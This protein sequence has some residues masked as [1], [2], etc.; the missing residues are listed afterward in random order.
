MAELKESDCRVS[1]FII[2]VMEGG[3]G[4]TAPARRAACLRKSCRIIICRSYGA[5]ML[6]ARPGPGRQ[7]A[8]ARGTTLLLSRRFWISCSDG[9][10]SLVRAASHRHPVHPC[11]R[12]AT[13]SAPS[14]CPSCLAHPQRSAAGAVGHS[15][16][17]ELGLP[18]VT[19]PENPSE[20]SVANLARLL[21]CSTQGPPAFARQYGAA[22]PRSKQ[23]PSLR[24]GGPCLCNG[25]RPRT[26]W[27]AAP[28]RAS[29]A[30]I[31]LRSSNRRRESPA[32]HSFPGH[33]RSDPLPA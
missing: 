2:V 1:G 31:V 11:D 19:S 24:R 12:T 26:S 14:P 20:L 30:R 5:A 18:G 16:S 4:K 7:K 27:S 25:P 9:S 13:L 10:G 17:A 32:F 15:Q 21:R 29:S 28:G 22:P 8:G 33:H 3:A 23:Q 6:Q